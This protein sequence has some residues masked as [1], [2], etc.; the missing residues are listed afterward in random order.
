MSAKLFVLSGKALGTIFSLQEAT[1]LGRGKDAGVR[2]AD[3]SVSRLHAR[4]EPEGDGWRVTDL[5]SSNG[6]WVAGQRVQTALLKDLDEFRA[7]ALELRIRIEADGGA[8]VTPAPLEPAKHDGVEVGESASEPHAPADSGADASISDA[9]SSTPIDTSGAL[10]LEGD[11]SEPQSQPPSAPFINPP[12][13]STGASSAARVAP[14]NSAHDPARPILQHVGASRSGGLFSSDL[15]QQPLLVRWGLYLLAAAFF[16][17][18]V[19]GVQH[20]V[21]GVR[22]ARSNPPAESFQ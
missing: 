4:I 17:G 1:I 14:S 11:W 5:D 21:F 12:T 16:V 2:L 18:L 22:K 3:A 20:L 8:E 6:I 10:E 15:G 7:G 9:D 13:S 19:W